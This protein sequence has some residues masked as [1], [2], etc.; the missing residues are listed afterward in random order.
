MRR[1]DP[2]MLVYPQDEKDSLS[3]KAAKPLY[4]KLMSKIVPLSRFA[5]IMPG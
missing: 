3:N 5:G 1:E 2:R 4:P